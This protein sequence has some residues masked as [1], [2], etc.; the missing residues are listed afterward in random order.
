MAGVILIVSV[1]GCT[2]SKVDTTELYTTLINQQR[3]YTPTRIEVKEGGR[4]V[5]EG[6]VVFEMQGEL[7]PIKAL[8]EQSDTLKHVATEATRLGLGIAGFSALD[9]AIGTLSTTRDPAIVEK[10]ILVPI[11]GAVLE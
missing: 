4:F 2:T 10:E 9:S 8:P 11:E 6:P 1:T 3:T 7:D 5:M